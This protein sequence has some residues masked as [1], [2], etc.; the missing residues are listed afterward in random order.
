L[1][2]VEIAPADVDSPPHPEV[3][4]GQGE[5]ILLVDDD[6][7]IRDVG[8]AI[9]EKHGYRVVHCA[10]G[11]EALEVFGNRADAISMVITDT[12]M[13][14]L[15]GTELARLLAQIRP[16]IRIIAM[17]GLNRNKVDEPGAGS[18]RTGARPFLIK[19]FKATD[20]LRAVH[21]LLH[22]GE[23]PRAVMPEFS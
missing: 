14:R 16:E 12:D 20:L 3:H 13:P 10:D 8:A 19:P 9:L 7:A 18:A 23:P 2:A 4:R 11:I 21:G 22:P 6:A 17:S 1:P 15:G 5:L